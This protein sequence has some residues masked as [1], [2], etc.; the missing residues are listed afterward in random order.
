MYHYQ[1]ILAYDGTEYGGWQIQPNSLTIQ[2]LIQEA[3]TVIFKDTIFV[4]GAGRTDAGV[5]AIA[6]SAHFSISY[7]IDILRLKGSLNGLLP[8]DI[9]VKTIN[10]VSESFHA[11]YS[12]TK[13]IYRYYLSLGSTWNPFTRLYSWHISSPFN[14]EEVKKAIEYLIGE[15][16]FC[17]FANVKRG[18][19]EEDTVRIL[20]RIDCIDTP[21]GFY[22]EFEGNGFLYKMVRN[23]MGTLVEVGIGK[24]SSDEIK[25]I[26][27]AR[28]RRKGGRTAPPHG[29]FLVEVIY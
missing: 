24:I 28:D 29:L 17:S 14:K 15:H 3:F 11:R 27:E 19:K 5:H 2:Q 4:T 16:D 13:K 8:R 6:Q 25:I 1:L 7:P 9:R 26:L 21:D 20:Y 10:P 23:L 18:F 22:F 12:S